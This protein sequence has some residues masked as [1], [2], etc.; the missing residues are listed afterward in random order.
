M[1][2]SPWLRM[3]IISP[4]NL[5]SKVVIFRHGARSCHRYSWV[6][7]GPWTRRV[8]LHLL[9]IQ[10]GSEYWWRR[11]GPHRC[12]QP[13]SGPTHSAATLAQLCRSEGANA[14]TKSNCYRKAIIWLGKC[15]IYTLLVAIHSIFLILLKWHVLFGILCA[16]LPWQECGTPISIATVGC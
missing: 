11:H 15:T 12:R 13:I 7:S 1:I 9:S 4:W 2:H 5:T 6:V 10:Y 14:T 3:I 16:I 8:R